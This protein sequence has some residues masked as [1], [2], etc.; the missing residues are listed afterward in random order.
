MDAVR[1]HWV[2]R[3]LPSA[4]R[5]YGRLAR[6]DR[7]IG[8][9]LLLLPCWWS[10]FLGHGIYHTW[11]ETLKYGFLF[12]IGAVS[13]RGA[14]CTYND[15]IDKDLD[16]HVARTRNRPLPAGDV[17]SNQAIVFLC[18][19]AGVG[20]WVLFQLPTFAQIVSLFSLVPVAFYPFAK[21]ITRYPQIFIGL[22]FSWGSLVGWSI[23]HED[24]GAGAWLLY[25]G[26]VAWTTGYDTIYGLQDREDDACA[27]I[28]SL[29]RTLG[30]SLIP[31]VC[32]LYIAAVLLISAAFFIAHVHPVAYLGLFF[33]GGHLTYQVAYLS[34]IMA[35]RIQTSREAL[36]LFR[37]NR[38]AG[39]L[40]CLG[41]FFSCFFPF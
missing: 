24:L 40:L 3:L 14:G 27:G 4:I 17:S 18:L 16:A 8:W 11:A 13:M 28:L 7:P 21:R 5:P 10:L 22:A 15:L 1:N 26:T 37:S 32:L 34:R 20:L 25:F 29:T 6:W 39:L 19:Q 33:F 35:T 36:A 31:G 30:D 23:F 38:T 9:W 41:L 12:F 2:D